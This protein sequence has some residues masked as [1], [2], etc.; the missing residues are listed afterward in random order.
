M[1]RFIVFLC[2]FCAA[3][4]L[5][6]EKIAVAQPA[7]NGRIAADDIEILWSTLEVSLGGD[8][9]IVTRDALSQMLVEIGLS[10]SG[11]VDVADI[12]A[13][14]G[15]LKGVDYLL[16]SNIGRIG[17]GYIL[18]LSVINASTGILD[19][20]ARTQ[21]R[22]ADFNGLIDRIPDAFDELGMGRPVRRRGTVALLA[23]EDHTGG[24]M[25]DYAVEYAS[26][27][28]EAALLDSDFRVR[29]TKSI[30]GLLADNGLE[31]PDYADPATF[32][33]M[34][35]VVRADYLIQPVVRRFEL[36]ANE[37]YIA[38]TR[39]TVVSTV[40]YYEGNVRIINVSSGET[41]GQIPFAVKADF[42]R[43]ARQT[44]DWGDKDY[45][46]YMVEQAVQPLIDGIID[47]FADE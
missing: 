1:K 26:T 30:E 9:E 20:D 44:A 41:V 4:C 37:R 33:R 18:T 8:Y 3:F 24:F 40:G 28:L 21:V 11:L 15:E 13:R 12:A 25:P 19:A 5:P 22:A 35:E 29:T 36:V 34:G 38:A 2:A 47:T 7:A 31:D 32:R 45:A 23:M 27:V 46:F 14:P 42:A 6:A 17:S 10:S 43:M 16:I 39:S